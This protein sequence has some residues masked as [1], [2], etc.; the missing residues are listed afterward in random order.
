MDFRT[1]RYFISVYE[2]LSLSSAAKRCLV[3]QPS[4][5]TAIKQLE[6]DL[7]R[8]LFVRHARGVSPTQAGKK[9][10][11]YATKIMT[12]IQ[13]MQ[14][15]FEEESPSIPLR[16]GLMPFLSG[17][18]VGTIIKELL[19]KVPSLDLTVVDWNED[20]DAR[21]I[22]DTMVQ[23]NE[24]F[25]KLWIDEYVLALPVGHPLAL[26][27]SVPLHQIDGIPFISRTFCDAIESWNFAIQEQGIHINT[28]ATFSTEEYALDLVAAGLGISLVPSHSTLL[29]PD[30]ITRKIRDIKLERVV[31]LAC[32]VDHPLPLQLLTILEQFEN[33]LKVINENH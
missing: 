26:Q 14:D 24:R 7:C 13:N 8:Q 5:S 9:L 2:E 11:P 20:T 15:L 25:H 10:Y 16:I 30:I 29:R 22:S 31:G 32:R 3:A 28:K 33:R 6:E 21:I 1:L 12:E 19:E 23:Q 17:V 27:K 18:L 4:I